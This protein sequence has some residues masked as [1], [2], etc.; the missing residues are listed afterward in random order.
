MSKRSAPSA[1]R[2]REPIAEVLAK[3]LPASGTVLELASGTGEHAV[4]LARRFPALLWQPSDIDVDALQSIEA[5][6][7]E[8]GFGN[9][10]PPLTLDAAAPP[11]SLPHVDAM[12]CINMA[13]I[14]AWP[15]TL[16]LLD[17]AGRILPAAGVLIFYGPWLVEG[18]STAP[19]NLE[20]DAQLRQRNPAW[21]LRQVEDLRAAAAE[22]GLELA[23]LKSMPANNFMILLNRIGAP[24]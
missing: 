1:V 24:R 10:L 23:A 7:V 12:L 6:R 16:G 13:H 3:W 4:Y 2:N 15:A 9:V 21:G 11:T 17:L 14:S 8:A 22:R 19:S 18:V 5:W 20:F